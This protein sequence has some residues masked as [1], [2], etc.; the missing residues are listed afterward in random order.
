MVPS[1]GALHSGS[2]PLW[3]SRRLWSLWD[4]INFVLGDFLLCL[5]TL[6]DELSWLK[7]VD[8]TAV[9]HGHHDRI[10][11]NI[12]L[13]VFP[14]IGRLHMSDARIASVQLQSM[15]NRYPRELY[16]CGMLSSTIERLIG[17]L[18]E[19]A[20]HE[21]FFHY[22]KDLAPL[23]APIVEGFVNEQGSPLWTPSLP[24]TEKSSLG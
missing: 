4:M 17:D 20:K 5:K 14:V 10:K 21:C 6:E 9:L 11:N 1:I 19:G 15:L 13:L 8:S 3:D 18:K 24:Q 12:D 22:P 16:T 23:S 7:A 2:H